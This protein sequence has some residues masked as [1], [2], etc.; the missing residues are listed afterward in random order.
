MFLYPPHQVPLIYL[1]AF[2]AAGVILPYSKNIFSKTRQN[3][4][5]FFSLIIICILIALIFIFLYSETKETIKVFSETV[6]PGKRRTCGGNGSILYMFSGFFGLFMSEVNF[7]FVWGNVCESS[8]FF[9]LF[10]ILLIIV[11]FVFIKK[12]QISFLNA[13][14][15]LYVLILCIYF[16]FGF[17]KIISLVTFFDRVTTNRIVFSLG[18]ASILWTCVLLNDI[19][20]KKIDIELNFKK[21]LMFS[22]STFILVIA[23]IFPYFAQKIKGFSILP[24]QIILCCIVIVFSIFFLLNGKIIPF[25]VVILVPNIFY[26]SLINP[27][28]VGLK[29]IFNNYFYQKVRQIAQY[30]PDAKWII[31]GHSIFANLFYTTGAKIF[32]GPKYIPNI[33][34]L[35]LISSDK[36]DKIIYNRYGYLALEPKEKQKNYF[37]IVQADYFKLY[38]NPS[39]IVW[40]KLNIKYVFLPDNIKFDESSLREISV[41][42]LGLENKIK[43]YKIYRYEK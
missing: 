17:P 28:C 7:P 1:S 25:F 39:D 36:N 5:R 31:Y 19:K 16:F 20:N 34:E 23:A 40:K 13:S 15:G 33:G 27:I 9:M 42:E 24:H 22:I 11:I 6:Y 4:F 35:E 12:R 30:E 14:F 21:L 29:P 18:I 2:I 8:N 10:P 26:H 37:K 3:N 41:I 43:K 38:I 32:N